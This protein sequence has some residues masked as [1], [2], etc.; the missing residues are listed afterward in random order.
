MVTVICILVSLKRATYDRNQNPCA[1]HKGVCRLDRE[2]G[3]SPFDHGEIVAKP[4]KLV[5]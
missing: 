5:G 4:F 1:I 2:T 3:V